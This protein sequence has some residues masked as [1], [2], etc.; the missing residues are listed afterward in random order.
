[1]QTDLFLV[2]HGE[3]TWNA[4]ARF[5]GHQ[6]S[7]LTAT[8]MAQAKAAADYLRNHQ[9]HALYSSDLPRTLQTARPIA[10]AT[11][12]PVIQEPALRERNLGI[13]EGLT[14]AEIEESHREEF[15]RYATREPHHVI[16]RGESLHELNQ[17]GLQIMERLA[18]RHGGERVVAVS[19]GALINTFMRHLHGIELQRPSPFQIS[20]GSVS[21]IRF[22]A[23]DGRWT[24][25][26]QNEIP[27]PVVES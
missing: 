20:N 26:R 6:D 1:M 13:F 8:G 19:H 25:I 27:N 16:P 5:Q 10:D 15:V 18:R 14:H 3:T 4:Q 12:L 2:R 24:I 23:V 22:D 21:H 7:P 9:L 17:R 11:G